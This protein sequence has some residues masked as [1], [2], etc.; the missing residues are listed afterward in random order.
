MAAKRAQ[1]YGLP[2]QPIHAS[3]YL[4]LTSIKLEPGS[5]PRRCIHMAQYDWVHIL[6]IITMA[7]CGRDG[8]RRGFPL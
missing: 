1:E 2:P 7:I 8:L 6:S 5:L 4:R 3:T